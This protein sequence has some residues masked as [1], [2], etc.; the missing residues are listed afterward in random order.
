MYAFCLGY[1]LLP[2]PRDIGC[3]DVDEPCYI[4]CMHKMGL[5]RSGP[6]WIRIYGRVSRRI[7]VAVLIAVMAGCAGSNS[8][9]PD[10]PAE[11]QSGGGPL[12]GGGGLN[13]GELPVQVRYQ[14]T[15]EGNWLKAEEA[16]EDDQFLAAQRYYQYIRTKFPYSRYA[17]LSEVRIGDCQ[18]E[19]KRYLEAIDT[20]QSFV[21]THPTHKEV[22]YA[23][24]RVGTGYYEQ[25]PGDFF[26]LPPS[27]EKD[28]TAVRD[29]ERKL[30]EYVRRF[31]KDE[32]TS[33]AQEKL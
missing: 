4:P 1:Q 24:Y 18:Y 5:L 25:I 7:P 33:K 3:P 8:A 17:A 19:R 13:R 31:P 2:N 32:N 20:Y 29:A 9:V 12:A 26:M 14:R 21:R 28:Q 6:A 15:A 22:P 11:D 23:M 27:H 16:Y 10:D 30:S